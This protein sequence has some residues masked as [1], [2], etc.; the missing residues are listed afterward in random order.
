MKKVR[1]ESPIRRDVPKIMEPRECHS[2]R[3]F[4]GKTL[5]A[6]DTGLCYEYLGIGR[7]NVDSP[8][9]LELNNSTPNVNYAL[10]RKVQ[11]SP[12]FEPS[13]D[14]ELSIFDN[15]NV[16]TLLY[17]PPLIN[18]PHKT[19]VE[20][21][22]NISNHHTSIQSPGQSVP[23]NIL[24]KDD[25]FFIRPRQS[26]DVYNFL[27]Q[28]LLLMPQSI[29]NERHPLQLNINQPRPRLNKENIYA[30]HPCQYNKENASPELLHKQQ[31]S[32]A[33]RRQS[34]NS[35]QWS[36]PQQQQCHCEIYKSSPCKFQM[37]LCEQNYQEAENCCCKLTKQKLQNKNYIEAKTQAVE[38][39][40][41]D[42]QKKL[43]ERDVSHE[44]VVAK[45]NEPTVADLFNIIK[46]QNEQLKELQNKVDTFIAN[47]NFSNEQHI[48][49]IS[50][51]NCRTEQ[52]AIETV[53]ENHKI[54]IG[55][56]TS[57][58]MVRTSTF[59]NKEISKHQTAQ[60]QCSASQLKVK[61]T[62]ENG[63]TA[64]VSEQRFLEG[65][66]PFD[67]NNPLDLNKNNC[68]NIEKAENGHKYNEQSSNDSDEKSVDDLSLCNLNIDNAITPQL[69]PDQTMYLDVRDYSE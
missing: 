44:G 28:D 14:L 56:M 61:E 3:P 2:P 49:P 26:T 59:I 46:V 15:S 11:T 10:Q 53:H 48:Q 36:V 22:Q 65:I 17:S 30:S 42:K 52:V 43:D 7:I 66:T 33:C 24:K 35:C 37:Q 41:K 62:K 32:I 18:K 55:V 69:S 12:P 68:N 51:E 31:R 45:L 64:V 8:Q 57:F 4:I 67:Y 21:V 34:N 9:R 6:I 63:K 1:F 40:E 16:K 39:F 25:G 29:T 60:V 23:P 20:N 5:D 13:T 19:H 58:E 38:K 54:S 47:T 27:N 50:L